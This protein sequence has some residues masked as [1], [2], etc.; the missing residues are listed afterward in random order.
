MMKNQQTMMT[1]SQMMTNQEFMGQM[2]IDP[3]Y[4]QQMHSM[5]IQNQQHM[6]EIIGPMISLMM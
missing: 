3:E 6:Q 1:N 4:V 2:M 5:M